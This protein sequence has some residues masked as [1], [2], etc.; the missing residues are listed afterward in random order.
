LPNV[1]RIRAYFALAL[2]PQYF[3]PKEENLTLKKVFF[4]KKL[5]TRGSIKNFHAQRRPVHPAA[6]IA[7][8]EPLTLS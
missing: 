3:R 2:L 8:L 1:G 4:G 7:L 5:K 6:L